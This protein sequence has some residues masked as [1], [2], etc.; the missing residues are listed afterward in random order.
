MDD[1]HLDESIHLLWAV[2]LDLC[3]ILARRCNIEVVILVVF[4]CC[5]PLDTISRE[6]RWEE[7]M[8]Y[9]KSKTNV[10]NVSTGTGDDH[11]LPF[12]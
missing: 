4:H 6:M 2:D 1:L 3:Y 8:V 9:E 11:M 7:T 5:L 12:V 10:D